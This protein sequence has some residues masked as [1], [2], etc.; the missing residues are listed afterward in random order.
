MTKR[1][2]T[3]IADS[4]ARTSSVVS[5]GTWWLPTRDPVDTSTRSGQMKVEVMVAVA[6]TGPRSPT[7]TLTESGVLD[8]GVDRRRRVVV[9]VTVIAAVDAA[10]RTPGC[11]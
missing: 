11:R 1:V 10:V 5:T 9:G 3:L 6:R 4:S 7:V 8:H 2:R